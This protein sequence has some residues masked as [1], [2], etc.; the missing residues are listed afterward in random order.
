M[1]DGI[2]LDDIYILE[3]DDIPEDNQNNEIIC[4]FLLEQ[5]LNY[6][7]SFLSMPLIVST[8]LIIAIST[9]RPVSKCN[10]VIFGVESF[11]SGSHVI[12][13]IQNFT[14]V[15]LTFTTTPH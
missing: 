3:D 11:Q 9:R 6:K 10:N 5:Y 2:Q 8:K 13:T 14:L 12:I 15:S 4:G 1:V 7:V